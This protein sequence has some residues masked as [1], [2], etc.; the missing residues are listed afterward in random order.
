MAPRTRL[1]PDGS[2]SSTG[3]MA[4]SVPAG[5]GQP[6]ARG[7][8]TADAR[9]AAQCVPGAATSGSGGRRRGSGSR[10]HPD[11]GAGVVHRRCFLPLRVHGPP[12]VKVVNGLAADVAE[13]AEGDDVSGHPRLLPAMKC[14]P[15]IV[16]PEKAEGRGAWRR[17]LMDRFVGGRARRS[18]GT[19]AVASHRSAAVVSRTICAGTP[20]ATECGG[21]LVRT[22]LWAP[23][24][25]PSPTVTPFRTTLCAPT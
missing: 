4:I 11:T 8:R 6:T 24:R 12:R 18:H 22:T 21:R 10:V 14:D 15:L 9:S 7:S 16:L 23:I 19:I 20:T 1:R 5:R 13:A 3:G 25:Q 2:L 17:V